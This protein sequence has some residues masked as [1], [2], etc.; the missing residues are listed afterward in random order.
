MNCDIVYHSFI[1][2]TFVTLIPKIELKLY[3]SNCSGVR[4]RCFEL[5]RRESNLL[6]VRQ[7]LYNAVL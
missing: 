5:N 2:S 4:P 1:L 3:L 6:N 7:L